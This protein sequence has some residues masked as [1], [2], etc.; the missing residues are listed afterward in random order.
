VLSMEI[1]KFVSRLFRNGCKCDTLNRARGSCSD[2][3][4]RSQTLYAGRRLQ[5]V[6][7]K[8]AVIAD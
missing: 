8:A 4:E 1:I 3:R 6:W 7:V 2:S 5:M